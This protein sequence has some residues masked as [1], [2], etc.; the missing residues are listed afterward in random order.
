[1]DMRSNESSFPLMTSKSDW[2]DVSPPFEFVGFHCDDRLVVV[3]TKVDD[4]FVKP[5]YLVQINCA[6]DHGGDANGPTWAVSPV[7]GA[8]GG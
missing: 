7:L 8:H 6:R 2:A 3:G 1:M 4:Q 5:G